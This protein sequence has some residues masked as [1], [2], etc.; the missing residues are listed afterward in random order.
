MIVFASLYHDHCLPYQM[1][2]HLSTAMK[3][4]DVMRDVQTTDMNS[5]NMLRGSTQYHSPS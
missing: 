1:N 4:V 5:L 3:E 2:A